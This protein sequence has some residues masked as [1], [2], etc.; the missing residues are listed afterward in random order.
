MTAALAERLGGEAALPGR[1]A[2]GAA[3]GKAPMPC[4]GAGAVPARAPRTVAEALGQ[5]RLLR[6]VSDTPLLD[7]Q[8]LLAD[9]LGKPRPWLLAHSEATLDAGAASRYQALLRQ[10]LDCMPV[11]YLLGCKDFWKRRFKVSPAAL[12]PRPESELL[13]SAA[14]DSCNPGKALVGDLGTGCGALAASLA[15]ERPA[16][17]L[18]ATDLSAAALALARQNATGLPNLLLVQADWLQAFRPGCFDLLVCNPPYLAADD[19]HLPALRHE[20]R[21]AL[22]ADE[23]GMGGL[24]RVA[25]EALPLLKPGGALLL[26][27]GAAQGQAVQC[28][29]QTLGYAQITQLHDL[30]GHPRAH[31]ASKPGKGPATPARSQPGQAPNRFPDGTGASQRPAPPSKPVG[32]SATNQAGQGAE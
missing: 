18:V 9:T 21:R 13:V 30:Q 24:R 26:E 16:W 7:C 27:H 20:P 32:G 6:A 15:A 12:I 31:F 4:G 1:T 19:P 8:L 29:L 3:A 17:T 10:R 23:D 25:T 14:L 22:V 5:A 2:G 28:L 11:A